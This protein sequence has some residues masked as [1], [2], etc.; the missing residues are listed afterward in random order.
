M[1]T[2]KPLKVFE[3]EAFLIPIK[4]LEPE[5]VD[6][7]V[8]SYTLNFYA[9]KLCSKCEF[10]PER[11]SETCDGCA[12]FVGARQ[13]AKTDN[14]DGVDVLSIPIGSK[15]RFTNFLTRIGRT[16]VK[17]ID[18]HPEPQPFTRPIKFLGTLRGFQEEAVEAI[19]DRK[20][21]LISSPPRSGKTVIV[22]AAVCRIGCKTLI[23]G[24]Q[25]EWLRQF[26]ET[27]LGSDTSDRFTNARQRQVNI[28]KT[29]QDFVDNDV[30]L[31]TFSR[32][33]S[34]RGK[35]LLK[36]I[37]SMFTFVAVDEVQTTPALQ[38]SRILSK[39]NSIY[40]IGVSGTIER[41]VTEEIKVS[42]LLMGPIIYRSK[43]ER[44]VPSVHIFYPPHVKPPSSRGRVAMSNYVNRLEQS[45]PRKEAILKKVL[46][47]VA[48]GHSVMIPMQRVKSILDWTRWLN[49]EKG[50][51]FAL[52]LFGGVPRNKRMDI[53]ERLRDGRSKVLIGN[54]R[55]ISVGLNIPRLSCLFEIIV[56]S[57]LPAAEQRMSRVLSPFEDKLPPVVVLCLDDSDM[58]RDCKRNEYFNVLKGRLNCKIHPHTEKDL[59]SYFSNRSTNRGHNF[60]LKNI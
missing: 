48:K 13:M 51:M 46:E 7:A 44:L 34:S 53:I 37:E 42:K 6:L 1:T 35:K 56:S 17:V 3:R 2:V 4:Q 50:S 26:R 27:F 10:L 18:L 45:T 25:E 32:F 21:G 31:A 43:V 22:T 14:V 38:T 8:D 28:C 16:E 12:A 36:Q 52:P 40:K 20:R 24:S 11:H 9:E 39:F 30:C 15:T 60:D 5:Q 55:I 23:L 58:I 19:I 47:Y 54:S 41:K 49:Q 59:L 33:M 57:N 29:Y